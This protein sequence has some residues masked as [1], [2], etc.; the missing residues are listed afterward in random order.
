MGL[1]RI[2]KHGDRFY[3][4]DQIQLGAY[5]ML[6]E[7]CLCERMEQG[8]IYLYGTGRRYS[9]PITDELRAGVMNP[10]SMIQSLNPDSLHIF[11]E[12]RNECRKCSVI[13]YCLPEE[14]DELEG[15][16]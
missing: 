1:Y 6:L 10:I 16:S 11:T 7:V 13:L 12:N 8:I 15:V 14:S 9:I 4:N 3:L 2:R 5:T